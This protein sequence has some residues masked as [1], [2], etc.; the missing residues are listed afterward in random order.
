MACFNI[1]NHEF[2]MEALR[3][4]AVLWIGR[5]C[6]SDSGGL[7]VLVNCRMAGGLYEVEVRGEASDER[8]LI[9]NGYDNLRIHWSEG[10][11]EVD[12]RECAR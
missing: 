9:D 4:G 8:A 10:Y 6:K 3:Y 7:S 1:E 5:I 11:L 12:I 2:I